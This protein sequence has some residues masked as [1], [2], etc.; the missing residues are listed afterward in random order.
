M[1][2]HCCTPRIALSVAPLTHHTHHSLPSSTPSQF[3]RGTVEFGGTHHDVLD[4]LPGVRQSLPQCHGGFYNAYASIKQQLQEELMTALREAGPGA[5]L[6][7]TGTE[8]DGND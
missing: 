4:R 3:T 6:F 7:V 8:R 1:W 5:R 2:W